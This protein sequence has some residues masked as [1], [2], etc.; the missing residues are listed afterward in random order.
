MLSGHQSRARHSAKVRTF[1]TEGGVVAVPG[2]DDRRVRVDVEHETRPR[3]T[4]EDRS[5]AELFT[6]LITS[7][8]HQ[9]LRR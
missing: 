4:L 1:G 8:N 6:T 9:L 2:V 3:H 5:A 7:P